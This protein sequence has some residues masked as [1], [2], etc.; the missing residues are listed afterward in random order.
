MFACTNAMEKS[1]DEWNE[2]KKRLDAKEHY[3]TFKEREIWW[4]QLGANVGYETNGS[5]KDFARPVLI[6]R[7][8]S[9]YVAWVIPLTRTKKSSQ[10]YHTLKSPRLGESRVI[11]TC[12][13]SAHLG[14]PELISKRHF[15]APGC[16][17]LS[18]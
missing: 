5:G 14:P 10:F 18:C 6:L 15:S 12:T 16:S 1:F 8:F 11:L 9:K 13:S 4:C 2:L 7:G 17:S 3:P